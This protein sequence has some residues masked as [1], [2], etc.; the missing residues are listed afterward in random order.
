VAVHD[1]VRQRVVSVQDTIFFACDAI[2][3]GLARRDSTVQTSPPARSA[4]SNRSDFFLF[5]F[6]C[7]DIT[8]VRPSSKPSI[9]G[10]RSGSAASIRG[11]DGGAGARATSREGAVATGAFI[12]LFVAGLPMQMGE[13]FDFGCGF[14]EPRGGIRRREHE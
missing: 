7:I 8:F 11:G 3:Y 6:S 13:E 4:R 12:D 1:L 14:E 10:Y 5:I 9:L 2:P